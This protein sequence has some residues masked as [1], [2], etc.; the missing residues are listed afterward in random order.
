MLTPLARIPSDFKISYPA[1]ISSTGSDDKDT[2][3]VSPI[4]SI[5][6]IRDEVE[7]DEIAAELDVLLALHALNQGDV[8]AAKQALSRQTPSTAPLILDEKKVLAAE[9]ARREGNPEKAS[10]F[11]LPLRGKLINKELAERAKRELV[12]SALAS[13]DSELAISAMEDWLTQGERP[14]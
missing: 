10:E 5:K 7:N 14:R 3:I 1:L 2:L 12:L 13:K 9:I 8:H 4:P 6:R 11:L